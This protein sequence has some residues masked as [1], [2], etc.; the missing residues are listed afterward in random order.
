MGREV[1]GVK[2]EKVKKINGVVVSATGF[3]RGKVHVAPK[4][5]EESIESKD[6]KVKDR[7][8]ENKVVG[9]SVENQDVLAVKSTNLDDDLTEG[10]NEKLGTQKSSDNKNSGSPALKS[11]ALGNGHSNK[12]VGAETATSANSS[13][14]KS[15]DATKSS[16]SPSAAKSS[17]SPTATKSPQSPTATKS[18]QSPNA[19]S[20]KSSQPTSPQSSSQKGSQ[21]DNK[22]HADEE[23]N[24]SVTSS[25]AASLRTPKFK[26]TVGQAPSFRCYERAEKRKEFYSKLEEKH[27][28]LESERSQWEARAKEEQEAAIKALRKS[29]VFKANPVPN[30]YYQAPPPKTELKKLPLTR[31]KSPKLNSLS[32]RKS[33]GDALSSSAEE[34]RRVCSREQRHSLGSQKEESTASMTPK[35]KAQ[36]G[37]RNSMGSSKEK[38]Q[39]KQEK[40]PTETSP[41]ITDGLDS[42]F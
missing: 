17:Q 32:R 15:A 28:A 12:A 33:C 29:M 2:V 5:S 10:K 39:L 19:E 35:N 37:R 42:F 24:S 13:N 27:Q 9:E 41:K 34:K 6:Y 1:T 18:P 11:V 8:E 7:I 26:V 4:I 22:K 31:P 25:T 16:Q 21:P 3:S 14:S 40:E 23:D 30:F 36:T 38:D 20:P